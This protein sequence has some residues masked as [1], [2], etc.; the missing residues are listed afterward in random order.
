VISYHE[1]RTHCKYAH[2]TTI[3]EEAISTECLAKNAKWA[4]ALY[5]E[6]IISA[7][8]SQKRLWLKEIRISL[9]LQLPKVS[10]K[11]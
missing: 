8:G 7:Q 9:L 1:S 6:D 10:I 5:Q 11:F 4:T 2:T 3:E